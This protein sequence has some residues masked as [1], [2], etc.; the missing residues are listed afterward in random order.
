MVCSTRV[1]VR[2]AV[3]GPEIQPQTSRVSPSGQS[4]QPG[5]AGRWRHV[6]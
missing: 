6:G 1:V 3:A 5:T 4:P 2:S